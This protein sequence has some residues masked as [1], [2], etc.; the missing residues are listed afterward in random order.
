MFVLAFEFVHFVLT[1]FYVLVRLS[2]ILQECSNV[3]NVSAEQGFSLEVEVSPVAPQVLCLRCSPLTFAV[4][5]MHLVKG[6]IGTGKCFFFNTI[7][8][9]VFILSQEQQYYVIFLSFV[10][11]AHSDSDTAGIY[12]ILC[13]Y[14]VSFF[15][16]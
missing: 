2:V 13:I 10:V 7:V 1:H 6:K 3:R 4:P 8:A 12:L 5:I 11:R 15:L 16:F 9:E 14:C